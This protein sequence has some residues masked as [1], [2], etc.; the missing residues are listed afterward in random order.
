MI[1]TGQLFRDGKKPFFIVRAPKGFSK[2]K[3]EENPEEA[4]TLPLSTV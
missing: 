1:G 3:P 2:G 4:L